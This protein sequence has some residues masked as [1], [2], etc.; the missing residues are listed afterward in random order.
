MN[1][2]SHSFSSVVRATLLTTPINDLLAQKSAIILE[3]IA[4]G[5]GATRWYYYSDNIRLEAIEAQ[6]RPGS[7]VSF[8]FDDRFQSGFYSLEIKLDAERI[9][10]EIGEVVVGVLAKD[11]LHIAVEM[12]T[13][14]N[15]LAEFASNTNSSSR[16][17]YGAFPAQ[18]ND[19]ARAVT[20]TLPDI[21]GVVRRHPH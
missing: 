10:A 3:R 12:V 4:M 19:G 7:I 5:G 9:I 20:V 17:F 1:T 15:E 6:L 16:V 2:Q 21:D 8:Y 14:P 11:G 18:D 13:G